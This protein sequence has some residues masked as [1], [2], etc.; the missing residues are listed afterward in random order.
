MLT[1]IGRVTG[2]AETHRRPAAKPAAPR[3]WPEARARLRPVLHT[4][5]LLAAI[6]V[7]LFFCLLPRR[8]AHWLGR[9][10]GNGAFC[11]HKRTRLRTLK[12]LTERL[13]VDPDE[14]H[15]LA[16]ASLKVCGGTLIDLLCAPRVSRRVVRRAIEVAGE[17]EAA[18]DRIR[19]EKKGYV[20]AASHFGNWEFT[21][22][23]W[24]HLGMPDTTV[25]VRPVTNPLLNRILERWRGWT[26]NRVIPRRNAVR[27]CVRHVRR[28]LSVAIL[29][30]IPVPVQS[31]TTPVDFFGAP[32]ATTL[33]PGYVAA[34]TGAPVYMVYL[35]PV[36]KGRYRLSVQGPVEVEAGETHRGTAINYARRL[37]RMLED[38]IRERPDAW[39]WWL[40]RWR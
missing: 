13:G 19:S 2:A 15:R 21:S 17:T 30:D 29:I 40:R 31:G 25:V 1:I 38:G 10:L 3:R 18:L 26:G 8:C 4:L 7:I 39:A 12:N 34:V 9:G 24:P 28:G 23:A 6:P 33:A 16:I 35:L 14:A 27:T 22:L 32:A 36:G 20:L 37:S 11:V 5:E